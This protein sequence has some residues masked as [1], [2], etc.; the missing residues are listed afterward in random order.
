MPKFKVDLGKGEMLEKEG[1]YEEAV[2]DSYEE[3]E[4]AAL[5]YRSNC[6]EGAEILNLSNPGD[7]DYDPDES[8]I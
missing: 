3:A 5:E 2:F 1:S 6:R 4:E 7:Y 8:V